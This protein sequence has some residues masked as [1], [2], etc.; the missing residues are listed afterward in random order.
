MPA[1][2][3]DTLAARS[4]AKEP[5]HFLLFLGLYLLLRFLFHE[6]HSGYKVSVI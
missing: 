2:T 6:H 5:G 3:G 4:N 1:K